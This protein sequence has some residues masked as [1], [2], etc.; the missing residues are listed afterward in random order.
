VEFPFYGQRPLFHLHAEYMLFSTT[1]W[2]PLVNGYS[3]HIPTEFRTD[4]VVLD[5]F[6]SNDSFAVLRRRR[7]RYIGVHWDMYGPRQGEIRDRLQPFAQH[8][9]ELARDDRMTLYEVVTFP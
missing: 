8:L 3:D 4:A 1:H 9:R 2:Q 6:P 7:V 5:S